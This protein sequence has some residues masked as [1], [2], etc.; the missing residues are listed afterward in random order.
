MAM[1]AP[2][3]PCSAAR[4]PTSSLESH[5]FL[6]ARLR[7]LDTE[8]DA[9]E[10]RLYILAVERQRVA[11]SLSSLI[12]PVL[13]LPPEITSQIFSH[14]ID[15]PHVGRTRTPGHGPLTL[16]SVCRHWRDL[17][18]SLRSLWSC[19]RIYPAD[20]R[21]DVLLPFLHCWLQRAGNHPLDLQ[22]FG[23]GPGRTT[24]KILSGLSQYSSQFRTLSITLD[25][26]FYLPD[27]EIRGKIPSL[28]KL[29]VNIIAERD[30]PVLLTA[31][32]DAPRLRD[33]RLSGASLE[34]ISLP[35]AQLTKLDFSHESTSSCVEILRETPNLEVLIVDAN[36]DTRVVQPPP[37]TL[38]RLHTLDLTYAREALLLDHLALPALK[39]IHL[40]T[41]DDEGV[42][43]FLALAARSDWVLKSM[44]LASMT[45]ASYIQCLH[46]M[47]SLKEVDIQQLWEFTSELTM[48]EFFQLLQADNTFLPALRTLTLR[49][50][51]GDISLAKM[52]ISRC[53]EE[54][55]VAKLET[56]RIFFSPIALQVEQGLLREIEPLLRPLRNAG[57][58][59]V[60]GRSE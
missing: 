14:Y 11:K 5:T 31:F 56:F 18:L 36:G 13:T 42:S 17:C 4:A 53:T 12:Y 55:G 1:M 21:A 15:E 43:R 52:L 44:H 29:A 16:A 48:L 34:W 23:S 37:L 41:L 7:E 46:P 38:S 3:R 25:R 8:M 35:W 32:S 26:P 58:H 45:T 28:A 9:L 39:C 57:L 60:V 47:P 27:A 19:L 10:S 2:S 40:A 22:V 33:V 50:F 49:D 30:L 51:G 54:N 20:F 59:V 6:R 24:Q